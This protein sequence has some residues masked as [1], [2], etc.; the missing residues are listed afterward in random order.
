MKHDPQRPDISARVEAEARQ[1]EKQGQ[2]Q[3]SSQA[4]DTGRNRRDQATSSRQ[5]S[6]SSRQGSASARQGNTN[7]A[8]EPKRTPSIA[9][10]LADPNAGRFATRF[11]DSFGARP[12]GRS[13]RKGFM[14]KRPVWTPPETVDPDLPALLCPHCGKPIDDYAQAIGD[15]TSPGFWHFDC[16]I[17]H[18]A[19]Q[20][21]L[22]EDEKIAYIGAGPFAG[23][24]FPDPRDSLHFQI[25]RILPWEDKDKRPEWRIEL[26]GKYSRT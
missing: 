26:A 6:S 16:A 24:F 7:R 5:G 10:R 18:L 19:E 3:G 22:R 8:P 4:R 14:G 25:R 11:G 1:K 13:A 23:V 17:A 20:E 9:D 15:A 12:A 2:N 21:R